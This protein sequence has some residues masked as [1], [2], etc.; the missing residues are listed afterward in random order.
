MSM[1]RHLLAIVIGSSVLSASALAQ[2]PKPE[3]SRTGAPPR[4]IEH[5]RSERHGDAA[6]PRVAFEVALNDQMSGEFIV[7]L[8]P[9]KAPQTVAN[10]LAYVDSGFYNDTVFDRITSAFV[11][12]AGG[13]TAIGQKKTAGL[14]PPVKY[15]GDNG[16]RNDR[17][18]LSMA[19]TWKQPDSATSEF[20]INLRDNAGLD[21]G[22]PEGDGAGYCVFGKIVDGTPVID[23]MRGLPVR[24]R[25][26]M[27]RERSVPTNPPVIKRAYRVGAD[28]A[29]KALSTGQ[30][31]TPVVRRPGNQPATPVR[32]TRRPPVVKPNLPPPVEPQP[33][34][35][36]M[37]EPEPEPMP[38][39]PPPPDPMPE[40]EP[41]PQQQPEP[42]PEP[43]PEVP[44]HLDVW[45]T[46]WAPVTAETV[47][48]AA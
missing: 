5:A 40:P 12:Q 35:E 46:A 29:A 48:G 23:R 4:G 38:E 42:E 44:P 37:P 31:T 13:Y 22:V 33:E 47:F 43:Q 10:F 28:Y 6:H 21:H 18:T 34:P 11:M 1:Q 15:E 41:D 8:Y 7:E 3:P 27:P 36:P 19:R 24:P 25:S 32:P 16:L 26:D 17:M 9:D 30:P 2:P 14:R 39:P 45:T 20:I